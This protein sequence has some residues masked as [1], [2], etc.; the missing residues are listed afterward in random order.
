MSDTNAELNAI[1]RKLRVL[2]LREAING[3]GDLALG[4]AREL[5]CIAH[6][7]ALMNLASLPEGMEAGRHEALS[8]RILNMRITSRISQIRNQLESMRGKK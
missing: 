3:D 5:Q 8:E 7:Q 2:M 4:Y 1:K 6:T